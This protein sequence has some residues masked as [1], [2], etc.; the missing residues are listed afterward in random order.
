VFASH[1]A[2]A[3]RGGSGLIV[4][5]LSVLDEE[6][7]CGDEQDSVEQEGEVEDVDNM[8]P[9]LTEGLSDDAKQVV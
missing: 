4:S 9:L 5:D 2:S 6:V 8:I 7:I 1:A 3:P